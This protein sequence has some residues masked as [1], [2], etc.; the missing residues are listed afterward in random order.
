M[1]EE[2]APF[3]MPG[4]RLLATVTW[5]LSVTGPGDIGTSIRM[6]ALMST[7]IWSMVWGANPGA[8][9]VTE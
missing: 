1:T 6:A 9:T 5:T 7:S 3:S 2:T 8:D 4:D